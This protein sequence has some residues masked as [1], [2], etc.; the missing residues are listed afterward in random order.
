MEYQTILLVEDNPDDQVLTR[1]ALHKNNLPNPLIVVNDGI[2]AIEYLSA[3]GKAGHSAHPP[4]LILLDLQLP[5][6]NGMEFLRHLR[7]QGPFPLIPVVVLTSSNEFSDLHECYRIGANSY[8]RKPVD[9]ETFLAT[10]HHLGL[11]WLLI[12]HPPPLHP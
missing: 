12:N 9:Y 1:R 11:Y 4:A 5:R 7:R 2:E 6:M 10:V 3:I 8:V